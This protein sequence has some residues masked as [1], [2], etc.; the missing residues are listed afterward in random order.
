MLYFPKTLPG[1][2]ADL[3]AEQMKASGTYR[4]QS[5]LDLLRKDFCNKC[6]LCE[7]SP[8]SINVEHFIPHEG[9]KN[10]E[11]SWTNLCWS[12]FHCNNIKGNGYVELLNCSTDPDIEKKLDYKFSPF[13]MESITITST[14]GSINSEVTST[15]LQ[16]IYNGT[17]IMKK[18]ESNDLRKRICRHI[19]DF[20]NLILQFHD[21]EFD[22]QARIHLG[23]QIKMKVRISAPFATFS[24]TCLRGYPV[25]LKELRAAITNFPVL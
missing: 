21:A 24:R 10:L 14:D 23:E 4:I 8:Q 3:T 1:P 15:L 20:V 5:V 17:T 6:Y 16:N 18:M 13:P 22:Q 7:D 19:N 9:D 2:Q 11:F 12:C 25:T